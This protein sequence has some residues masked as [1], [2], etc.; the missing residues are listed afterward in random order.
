M[1]NFLKSLFV[2]GVEIDTAGA[3]TG[4]VL[5]YNGSKFGAA[6][7]AGGG[8]GA[9]TL[10]D[11]TDVV[12]T[13]P[14]E[15][16]GLLYNGASWVNSYTPVSTYVRNAEA[17][18]LTIGT[19]V[20]LF[21]ATGDHASVKRADNNSDTTSS[22][23]IGV[24]GASITASNNGPIVTRGYVDGIDLSTGYTAGDVLWLGEAGA[25]TTTKPTAPDHLVFI[26]VVVRATNNGIIYVATQNGY[27]L[28]ELHNVSLPSP[29]SGDFLKYNGSLW[30]SD[31][32]DLGTDTTGSYV[33][34]LVAGT[35]ITLTNNSGEGATPTIAVNASQ[36]GITTVGTLGSLAVT[37]ALTVDTNTL[38]VDATNNRVGIGT[39]TP[40]TALAVI[41]PLV[42]VSSQTGVIA[43]FGSSSS[44]RLLVGSIT[45]TSA[46]IG[47]EGEQKLYLNTNATPRLTIES[48]GDVGIGTVSPT[49]KLDVAGTVT[50]YSFA[51]P[52]ASTV[53]AVTQT[54]ADNSTKVATTA[55]VTAA[56]DLKQNL[57]VGAAWT[58]TLGVGTWTN[59]TFTG[60][61][62]QANKLVQFWIL[63]TATGACVLSSGFTPP[64]FNLPVAAQN[65]NAGNGFGVVLFDTSASISY[66][67]TTI[68]AS[69][70]VRPMVDQAN[71]TYT[72]AQQ[73]ATTVPFTWA[74]GDTIFI[75]G[76]YE[77]S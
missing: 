33:S 12:I 38:V 57:P 25:F 6:S 62:V 26:G 39:D 41:G 77:A 75:Q 17:T 58:P 76:T 69:N 37:G 35:G 72:Y 15:F 59:M 30:V 63:G 40:S 2:K 50:A 54:A 32:I 71:G 22:K 52:L 47:S 20:Y 45:G 73:I 65:A 43:T 8:G 7:V 74:S 21:G 16:Q 56:N 31:A 1:A 19:C 49:T 67:G 70:I 68:G 51:G 64:F 66:T 14:E 13:T 60:R 55:F 10:D 28:D 5:K 3:I 53:T 42:T 27:E 36:T 4:D 24:V 29:A 18:T 34:S 11:L 48:G 9:S 61:Y 44:G 46:F 23:T